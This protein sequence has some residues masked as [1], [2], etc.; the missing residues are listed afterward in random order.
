[1]QSSL[2][3][4]QEHHNRR[5]SKLRE[6]IEDRRRLVED[7]ESGERRLGQED[8][9]RTARQLRNF[10]RKLDRL[11]ETNNVVSLYRWVTLHIAERFNLCGTYL[12]A[13]S[14]SLLPSLSDSFV[15]ESQGTFGRNE[16]PS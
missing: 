3:S 14:T 1:M 13:I 15:G 4:I 9:D 2:S 16:V 11:E 12:Y 5:M 8:F 10:Q 6:M 7:H